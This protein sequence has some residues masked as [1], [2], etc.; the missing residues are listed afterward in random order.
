M[1]IT[2]ER[3]DI[4]GETMILRRDPRGS[5]LDAMIMEEIV[6]PG[7]AAPWHRHEREDEVCCVIEGTFRIWR[8][9]EVLDLGP[10]GVAMLPRNQ[11]HSFGC[12]GP[13]VGRILTVVSPA[14]LERFFQE[15]ARQG[16]GDEDLATVTACAAA[17]GLEILGPP[18]SL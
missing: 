15:V 13:G 9:E 2:E 12:V 17:F 8:G 3:L 4:F 18:P 10:G 1:E 14:G 6:P 16:W 7:V 11:A 5:R